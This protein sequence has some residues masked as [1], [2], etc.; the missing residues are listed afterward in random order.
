MVAVA[1]CRHRSSTTVRLAVDATAWIVEEVSLGRTGEA[2]G[3]I[4]LEWRV[5]RAASV[6]VHHA[7]RL[8]LGSPGWGS[9]VSSGRHRHLV[10]ALSVGVAAP[11]DGPST[12]VGIDAAAARLQVA[13]DAWMVLAV[14][15]DRPAAR[16]A[17]GAVGG[18]PR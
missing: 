12:Q 6:L 14:G 8:G 7:E 2:P 16:A 1:G 13:E 3:R 11:M 15:V 4:D 10:A 5:E 17:M 18:C 9:A